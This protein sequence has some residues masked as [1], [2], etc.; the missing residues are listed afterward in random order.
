MKAAPGKITYYTGKY[1]L[2][3][4]EPIARRVTGFCAEDCPA[5]K[6]EV[7]SQFGTGKVAFKAVFAK[8]KSVG[9]NGPIMVEGV[10]VGATASY[11]RTSGGRGAGGEGTVN[12]RSDREFL[13]T[14]AGSTRA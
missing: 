2:A 13:Q 8:L 7:V 5:P 10:K 6:G 12:G 9:F 1:Q 4:L 14:V 11:P 3:E